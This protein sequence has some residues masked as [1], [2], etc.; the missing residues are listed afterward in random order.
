MT[1]KADLLNAE[2]PFSELGEGPLWD[3]KN[4]VF[5]WV[6]IIGKTLHR[7]HLK[8]SIHQESIM[9]S[10]IGFVVQNPLGELMV[11]LK[12]G[13]Y[14][15]DFDR[16]NVAPVI[17]PPDMEQNCRFNDGKCDRQGRLWCGTMHKK[18]KVTTFP[19]GWFT[20]LTVKIWKFLRKM[21]L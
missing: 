4:A 14:T 15:V 16:G 21:Y 10:P 17:L 6:D 18:A 2:L 8:D 11:G 13:I 9:P 3:E 1:R 5:Y 7:F 20:G 19:K 12:E